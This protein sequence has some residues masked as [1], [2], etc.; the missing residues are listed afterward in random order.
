VLLVPVK[1]R[2]VRLRGLFMAVLITCMAP[3]T[4]TAAAS[5]VAMATFR[6]YG[7]R[8]RLSVLD[9][10]AII[11]TIIVVIVGTGI[12]TAISRARSFPAS[13]M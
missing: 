4:V 9:N 8:R 5:I 1:A 6:V 2:A 12:R 7:R 3:V 11:I 13:M 10:T